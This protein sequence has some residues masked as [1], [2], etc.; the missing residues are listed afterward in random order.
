MHHLSVRA[1]SLLQFAIGKNYFYQN[2]KSKLYFISIPAQRSGNSVDPV[3]YPN[4]EQLNYRQIESK[5]LTQML[6]TDIETNK[7][8][9]CRRKMEFHRT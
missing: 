3:K 5:E 9:H 1:E 2:I 8:F 7:L 4:R 6:V